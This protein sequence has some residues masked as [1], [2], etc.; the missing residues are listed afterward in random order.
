MKILFISPRFRPEIGGVE[1]HVYLVSSALIARGHDVEVI[2]STTRHDLKSYQQEDNLAVHRFY[3][4]KGT[5]L[6]NTFMNLP[7]MWFRFLRNSQLIVGND[8][9]HLHDYETFL[10]MLPFIL[11]LRKKTF[12][13]FHGFEGYPILMYSKIVRKIAEKTV[14]G[15]ICIG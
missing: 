9:I 8:V 15:S 3:L 7:K 2:T 12:I 6:L 13:T 14:K 5:N 10:W 11:F 1:K 4:M